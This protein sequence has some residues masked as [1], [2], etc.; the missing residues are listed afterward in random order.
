VA[1]NKLFITGAA[2]NWISTNAVAAPH[3]VNMTLAILVRI[4]WN[5]TN[6][7]HK[8]S[9]ELVA[10]TSDGSERV[11]INEILP[12]DSDEENRGTIIGLFNAGR[13]PNMRVG[14]ETLMPVALPFLGLPLPNIGSYFFSIGIDGTEMDRVSFRVIPSANMQ[15]QMGPITP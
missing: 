3:P 10:D 2:I 5:A 6:Q 4:P 13:A 14:E 15:M 11:S 8:L 12:P 9:I 7:Q 1:G